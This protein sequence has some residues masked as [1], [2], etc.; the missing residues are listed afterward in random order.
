MVSISSVHACCG[1]CTEPLAT[2]PGRAS[3]H[4][5]HLRY[6]RRSTGAGRGAVAARAEVADPGRAG[7][8]GGGRG[9]RQEEEGD[10]GMHHGAHQG[11]HAVKSSPPPQPPPSPWYPDPTCTPVQVGS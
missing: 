1:D 9:G 2:G 7:G 10:E 8:T 6:S 5:R 11:S 3:S 4:Q